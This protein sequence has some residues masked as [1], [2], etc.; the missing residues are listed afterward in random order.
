[1]GENSGAVNMDWHILTTIPLL[2]LTSG[3]RGVRVGGKTLGMGGGLGSSNSPL[4][5]A[6]DKAKA[7]GDRAAMGRIAQQMNETR[8]KQ[9]QAG[10]TAEP[11]MSVDPKTGEVTL[12]Y[13]GMTAQQVKAYEAKMQKA[14]QRTVDDLGGET[15]RMG[16]M[17]LMESIQ[18]SREQLKKLSPERL[19]DLDR[20]TARVMGEFIDTQNQLIDTL[21]REAGVTIP[22]PS[23]GLAPEARRALRGDAPAA[24]P[25]RRMSL[26]ESAAASSKKLAELRSQME[27]SDAAIAQSFG[28]VVRSG[29][30]VIR[31][32]ADM[33]LDPENPVNK[34]GGLGGAQG[35][36]QIGG[37]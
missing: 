5:Q 24:Q 3:W 15:R 37:S 33:A 22:R 26:A 32:L 28:S 23:T 2:G 31:S 21:S 12:D 1:M 35:R 20:R 13:S 4:V 19:N 7:D 30:S 14:A 34:P 36:R 18:Y 8:L 9:K 11:K 29:E 10:S 25:A 16:Q 17:N 6:F 27:R